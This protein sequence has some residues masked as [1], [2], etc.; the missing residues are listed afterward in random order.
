MGR[1]AMLLQHTWIEDVDAWPLQQLVARVLPTLT[2]RRHG[3]GCLQAYIAEGPFRELRVHIWSRDLMLE[4]I[5]ESGN[6]H[7]HRFTMRSTVLAGR[8]LHTEHLID[9]NDLGD[10]EMW[11]FVHARLHDESNRS[12]MVRTGE[13]CNVRKVTAEIGPWRRYT[14]DKFRFHSS[15]PASEIAVTLVE[16]LDQSDV[17]A[18]VVAPRSKPPVPAFS[19]PEIRPFQLA[20]LIERAQAELVKERR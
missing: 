13:R 4:G 20:D 10:H 2:W 5:E 11:T 8:L 18:K 7:N 9:D 15:E 3:I 16:K 1:D 14:F 6:A 17:Q 12:D 19:G